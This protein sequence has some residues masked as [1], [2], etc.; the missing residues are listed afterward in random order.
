MSAKVL[1]SL[2]ILI[3]M[4]YG[5][6]DDESKVSKYTDFDTLLE[7]INASNT[8][9]LLIEDTTFSSDIMADYVFDF[10]YETTQIDEE[11]FESIRGN[12]GTSAMERDLDT[13]KIIEDIEILFYLLRN[14]YVGYGYFGGDTVF[15]NAK[16]NILKE[17]KLFEEE[18]K[19]LGVEDGKIRRYGLQRIVK[20]IGENLSFIDKDAHFFIDGYGYFVKEEILY[21]NDDLEVLQ[22]NKGYYF[23][24]DEVKKYINLINNDKEIEKHLKLTITNEGNLVY[25]L[26]YVLPA[27]PD[28]PII[29][30]IVL[31]VTDENNKQNNEITLRLKTPTM[32]EYN[33]YNN[34]PF[35]MDFDKNPPVLKV[36]NFDNPEFSP[37]KDDFFDTAVDLRNEEIFIIDLRGNSGGSSL[38]GQQWLKNYTNGEFDKEELDLFHIGMAGESYKQLLEIPYELETENGWILYIGNN[39]RKELIKNENLIFVLID[40]SI[41]SASENFVGVLQVLENVILVG[42]NTGGYTHIGNTIAMFL[43]YTEIELSYG[44]TAFTKAPPFGV[45]EGIGIMPDIWIGDSTNL[46]AK[47]DKFITNIKNNR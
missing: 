27:Q 22:D 20:I 17:I 33:K 39:T 14:V 26:G 4:M 43:P 40:E 24:E 29:R 19:S 41:A 8:Q 38:F 36:N 21:Y 35:I 45:E 37:V 25:M 5:C 10:E 3:I 9:K 7:S 47:L 2:L 31:D 32:T 18:M 12:R 28:V 13:N 11:T 1:T 30:E 16:E 46:A 15:N 23:Y 42:R 34:I 6:A 44:M